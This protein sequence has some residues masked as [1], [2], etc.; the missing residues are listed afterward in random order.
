MEAIFQAQ[1][2]FRRDLG[3]QKI[4]AIPNKNYQ[5]HGTKSY[6]YLMNRFGFNPTKPGPYFHAK[7]VHQRGLMSSVVPKGGRVRMY[8]QLVK[9]TGEDDTQAGEVTAED[10]QND[11]MYLCEVDI[12]TPAQKLMLDFDTGSSDLWVRYSS[13]STLTSC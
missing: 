1:A 5:R 11:S 6:V 7:R 2:K 10:Q 3:L 8:N 12:G 13:A 9:K 4:R